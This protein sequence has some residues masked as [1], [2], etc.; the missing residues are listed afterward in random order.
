MRRYERMPG[1]F[2]KGNSSFAGAKFIVDSLSRPWNVHGELTPPLD[3]A[4]A[5]FVKA[6]T[7]RFKYYKLKHLVALAVEGTVVPSTVP[8]AGA[9]DETAYIYTG[10]FSFP[11]PLF[12]TLRFDVGDTLACAAYEYQTAMGVTDVKGDVFYQQSADARIG[13]MAIDGANDPTTL[14]LTVASGMLPHHTYTLSGVLM[15][16]ALS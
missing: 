7:L 14:H 10:T 16:E 9:E 5:P 2:L 6:S 15:Y 12:T 8:Y 1:A 3:Q 13:L 11:D 4:D